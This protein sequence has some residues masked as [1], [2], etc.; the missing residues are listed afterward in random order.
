MEHSLKAITKFGDFQPKA[1]IF[2]FDGTLADSMGAWEYVDR[3]FIERHNLPNNPEYNEKIVALGY[4]AGAEFVLK[5]FDIGMTKEEI[6]EEWKSMAQYGYENEILLKPYVVE[7]LNSV[8]EQGFHMSIA[9]SLQRN[10]LEPCLKRNGIIEYFDDLLICDELSSKGK[11]EP[12]VYY[13]AAESLNED[14]SDCVVFEDISIAAKTARKAGAYTIGVRDDNNQEVFER[15]EAAANMCI[16]S[17]KDL[18]V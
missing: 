11:C 2:D 10:L 8:R 12:V 1:F 13:A 4:D 15:L 6:V 17:F 7:Y 3:T 9:T 18:L 5:T 14:L 16:N